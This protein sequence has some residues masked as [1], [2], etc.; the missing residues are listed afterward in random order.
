MWIKTPKDCGSLA[1]SSPNA[2][3]EHIL[4]K[5]IDSS[6][7]RDYNYYTN[8][9]YRNPKSGRMILFPSHLDHMVEQ[10]QSDEDRISI[11]F[12]FNV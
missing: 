5:N 9:E 4:M 1:F 8:F 11:A 7:Q 10:S 12:N 2:F 6:I 3:L